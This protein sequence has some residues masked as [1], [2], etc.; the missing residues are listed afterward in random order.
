MSPFYEKNHPVHPHIARYTVSDV[1]RIL[2]IYASDDDPRILDRMIRQT[3][4]MISHGSPRS[5]MARD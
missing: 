4:V 2:C 3:D 1:P 5:S